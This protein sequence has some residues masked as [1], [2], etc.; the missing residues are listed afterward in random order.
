MKIYIETL[1]CKVNTYESEFVTNK[2]KDAG[3]EI[4]SFNDFCDVYIINTC[5]VTNTADVKSKKMIRNAIKK[6]PNAIVVAM[7][8]FIA[9]NQKFDI[10]G[11]DI[12]IGNKDKSRIV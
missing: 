6:N 5:T 10:E 1:G 7:G 4:A 2:L 8:C 11:L 9:A 12:V 3:Y